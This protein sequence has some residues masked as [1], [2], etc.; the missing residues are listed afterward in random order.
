ML[1]YLACLIGFF[2]IIAVLPASGQAPVPPAPVQEGLSV[3]GRVGGI[4]GGILLLVLIGSLI[5]WQWY[6]TP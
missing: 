6:K 4:V 3:V 5:A 2:A 1:R